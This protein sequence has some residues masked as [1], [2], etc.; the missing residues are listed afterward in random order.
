MSAYMNLAVT[1]V[2][3]GQLHRVVEFIVPYMEKA[4]AWTHGRMDVDDILATLFGKHALL[5]LVFDV[6]TKDIH[7]FL[8][9]EIRTYP[10]AKHMIVLNCGGREGSL[11]ACVDLVFDTF[12]QFAADNGCD[13]LD[14]QGRA[15]WSKFTKERG[16]DTGM[17]H[18]FK[19]IEV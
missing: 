2:P 14:I 16:Y 11:E 5:W 7:G 18:Y 8:T 17:R 19:K 12:E 4:A 6:S 3:Y 13:G 9:T 10:Q 1:A 15:A